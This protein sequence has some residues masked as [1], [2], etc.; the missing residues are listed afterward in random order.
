M[1]GDG[2]VH[3]LHDDNRDVHRHDVRNLHDGGLHTD[4]DTSRARNENADHV[5]E[6]CDAGCSR[7][8]YGHVHGDGVN[9]TNDYA[10]VHVFRLLLHLSLH[11]RPRPMQRL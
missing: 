9:E 4:P 10:Y 5:Y 6:D 2:H 11:L 7:Y 3:T 8:D 1:R